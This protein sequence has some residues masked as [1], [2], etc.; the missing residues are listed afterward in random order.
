MFNYLICWKLNLLLCLQR[1]TVCNRFQGDV[2]WQLVAQDVKV[3]RAKHIFDERL[4]CISVALQQ[5]VPGFKSWPLILHGL[6]TFPLCMHRLSPPASSHSPKTMAVRLIGL[7]K[8][9]LGVSVC[10][11]GCLSCVCVALPWTGD[12]SFDCGR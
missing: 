8:F 12:L 7:S 4:H 2:F 3:K 9:S 1:F 6:C 5:D 10:L 11:H